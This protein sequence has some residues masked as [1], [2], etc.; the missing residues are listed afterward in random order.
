MPFGDT[1]MRLCEVL[2]FDRDEL[3][4]DEPQTDALYTHPSDTFL[5][6]R[7]RDLGLTLK[8]VAAAAGLSVATLSRF[9]RNKGSHLSSMRHLADVP[10][11][12]LANDALA[13]ILQFRDNHEL[14]IFWKT[15][16][17]NSN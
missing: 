14:T 12:Q 3:N 17:T 15:G 16:R 1:A 9:E 11:V 2:G 4:L 8:E 7:R 6:D 5:R 13:H 10:G